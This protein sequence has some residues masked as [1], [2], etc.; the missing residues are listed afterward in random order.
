[1]INKAEI[2][3]DGNILIQSA[4]NSEII[5]NV[6]N[7]QEIRKF[8]IDFQLE[9]SNIPTKIINYMES[10]K[11]NEVDLPSDANIFLGI[12]FLTGLG[13]CGG[14]GGLCFSVSITNLIKEN[15][16]FN[17]PIFKSSET[18]EDNLD[19]FILTNKLVDVPFPKKLEYGEPVSVNYEITP[20]SKN[21]YQQIFDKNNEATIQ[22]IVST[23]VGEIFKSNEYKVSKIL[24]N[25][26]SIKK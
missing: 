6:S 9:L 13:L 3:G 4:D 7:P 10:K 15:R 17:E 14:I 11:P 16:Y 19:T 24:K 22:V 23:T 18:F 12:S 26:K 21:L 8:L 5:I 25:F 1:M 2:Q 20:N